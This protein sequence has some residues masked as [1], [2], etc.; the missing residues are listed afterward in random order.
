MNTNGI[1]KSDAKEE[2]TI[3]FR[4]ISWFLTSV[5]YLFGPLD[6]SLKYKIA[7]VI[8]LLIF[9][10]VVSYNYLA[11]SSRKTVQTTMLFETTVL[12]ILLI[13]TGGI[14]SPFLWYA[15][16]PVFYAAIY[17]KPLY[18]WLNLSFYLIASLFINFKLFNIQELTIVELIQDKYHIILAFILVTFALRL[19]NQMIR[20]LDQQAGILKG[21]K[22]ELLS[23]NQKLQEANLSLK[24]SI[25]Y[26]MSLYHIIEASS[27]RGD[28][29]GHLTQ[30]V[31]S[32]A[33]IT[34][35]QGAFLWLS[36]YKDQAD[37]FF[38]NN[39]SY[40][41]EVISTCLNN[42]EGVIETKDMPDTFAIGRFSFRIAKIQS[43]SR[44]Y[45]FIGI[46]LPLRISEGLGFEN[47]EPLDSLTEIVALVL[48]RHDLEKLSTKVLIMEEQN[49]IANEIHDSVSQRLFSLICGLHTLNANW[50]QYDALMIS[51]QLQLLKQCVQET[52]TEIR[53]SIYRLSS[54]KR[55][56]KVFKETIEN[57]LNDFAD[58]NHVR[59]NFDFQGD[60]ERIPS[61]LR[62]AI[63]RIVCESTGNAVRHGRCTELEVSLTIYAATLELRVKD[64]GRGFDSESVLSHREDRGLGL[65][66]MQLLTQNLNGSFELKSAEKL[67]SELIFNFPLEFVLEPSIKVKG[68]A[69]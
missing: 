67:G 58:L 42:R 2:I 17:L 4:Y 46:E 52:S 35:S 59:V 69:A 31:D 8:V 15:L 7:I 61:N 14:E 45:G 24:R 29:Q 55:G 62:K 21:E 16:N 19:F 44:F 9:S 50:R 38:A 43:S 20:E 64:N 34:K 10:R 11:R 6:Y 1:L 56:E 33:K 51:K 23:M 66:N 25:E 18:C 54:I 28:I 65:N 48:E 60:E 37:M 47:E 63:H 22:Q 30:M 68:G 12:S 13:P 53:S 27:S 3:S 26:V 5:F 40:N 57:Y 36:P 49:R 32:V 41:K 39:P